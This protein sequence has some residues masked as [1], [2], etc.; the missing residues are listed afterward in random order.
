MVG[1]ATAVCVWLST[2]ADNQ[3]SLHCAVMSAS[4]I[5]DVEMQAMRRVVKVMG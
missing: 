2:E 1:L 3:S 4:L 5:L